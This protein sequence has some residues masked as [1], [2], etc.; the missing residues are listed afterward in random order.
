MCSRFTCLGT[1]ESQEQGWFMWML[2]W[3]VVT[4]AA[5]VAYAKA[6]KLPNGADCGTCM[7]ITMGAFF[8]L[9]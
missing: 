1:D 3:S 4:V 2:I 8:I 6:G 7:V 5:E 9:W